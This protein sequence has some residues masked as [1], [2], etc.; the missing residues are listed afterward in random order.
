M[1]NYPNYEISDTIISKSEYSGNDLENLFKWKNGMNLSAKKL[2]SCNKNILGK[3]I[4]MNHFKKKFDQKEFNTQFFHVSAIWQIFLLHIINHVEFPIFDQHVYR[5]F[6]YFQNKTDHKLPSSKK[7]ILKI[8]H[9]EYC[10]FFFKLKKATGFDSFR[11]DKALWT[12]GKLIKE[13]PAMKM[14]KPN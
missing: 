14:N 12:F 3:E 11:V 10:E 7:E 4:E 13:Y 1:Y 2:N 8:Y 5:A 9:E 6:L